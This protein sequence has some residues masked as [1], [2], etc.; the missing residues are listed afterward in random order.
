MS[1]STPALAILRVRSA[2]TPGRSSTSTTTTSRSRVTARCEI[3]SACFAASAWGTRM[4]NS[5]RSPA[6]TQVAAAMFTPASLIAAAASARAP[7]VFSM[8]MTR[9]VAMARASL[10]GPAVAPAAP[11]LAQRVERRARQRRPLLAHDRGLHPP[12]RGAA[13]ERHDRDLVGRDEDVQIVGDGDAAPG[14]DER[15]GLDRLVAVPGEE[16]GRVDATAARDVVDE[17]RR[18]AAMRADPGL[19]GEVADAQL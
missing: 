13:C 15:L 17:A 4:C 2:R 14:G 8:S 5:A 11:D 12:H 10:Q 6:P 19:A 3:A 9:S 16:Q 18:R 1:R 7:G